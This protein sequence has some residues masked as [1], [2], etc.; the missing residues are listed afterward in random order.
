MDETPSRASAFADS[1]PFLFL[2]PRV[3]WPLN[4]GA[5]IRTHALL[6]ALAGVFA[7]NYAGFLQPDLA[8]EEARMQLNACQSVELV[9]EPATKLFGKLALAGKNLFDA[10]PA[11]L[12]K[13]DHAQLREYVTQWMAMNPRGIVH[14]DHLHMAGYL[15]CGMARLKIIDEHNVESQIVERM[16]ERYHRGWMKP[17]LRAQARRMHAC[18]V[19]RV[20][21]A[22]L[23]LAVSE[24]DAQ[25]LRGMACGAKVL[26]VPNGVDLD[27]FQPPAAERARIPK[28]LVFTGSMNWLPNEDAMIWFAE[29]VWPLLARDYAGGGEW[30]LDIVGHAPSA[31]VRAL[32]SKTVHVSG[33]VP[34]VRDYVHD[35]QIFIVPL[36]IGGGSRLKILE[37]FAMQIPVISTAVGCEGLGAEHERHLLIADTPQ[38]FAA[39]TARLAQDAALRERLTRAAAQ[40]VRDHFSWKAIGARLAARYGETRA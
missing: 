34:D 28:R 15:N 11:T 32:A 39:A 25:M 19:E 26:V 4:T 17:W 21:S 33:S 23:T 10:R 13:Y 27:Y 1:P 18:E 12:A 24:G 29:A 20:V 40:H 9:P 5:K 31:A 37:A 8:E 6:E 3:P 7:V 2:S 16:A 36:R 14:A 30:S 35:A 38:A 22:N